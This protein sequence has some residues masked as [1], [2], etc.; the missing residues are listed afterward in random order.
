MLIVTLKIEHYKVNLDLF[1]LLG[2]FT[3]GKAIEEYPDEENRP[4]SCRRG[5]AWYRC[6]IFAGGS[7]VLVEWLCYAMLA[8]SPRVVVAASSLGPIRLLALID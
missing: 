5:C 4:G 1:G 2:R 3:L 7:P 6:F 8:S